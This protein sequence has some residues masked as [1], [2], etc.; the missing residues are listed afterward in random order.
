MRRTGSAVAIR[1]LPYPYRAALTITGDLD[2][3]RTARDFVEVVRFLGGTGETPLGTG[4]GLELS[5][6]FWFY[7]T[8][9]DSEFTVFREGGPE[10]TA[11][12]GLIADLVASGHVDTMHTYGNFSEGGFRR[13]HAERALS[14]LRERR[15]AVPVWVNHGGTKNTQ[16]VG[17]LPEQ[18]GDDPGSVEYHTDLMAECGVRFVETFDVTHTVGQD[19]PAT[20]RDRA[21]QTYEVARYLAS[22]DRGRAERVYRNALVE[23]R[24]LGDGGRFF[25][26]KRFIGRGHGME[27]AGSAELA[28]QLSP[29]VLSELV[30]KRGWMSVYTHPWR[31]PGGAALIAPAAVQALRG[32]AAEAAAGRIYVTTT[33][34]LLTLNLVTRRLVWSSERLD[35][36]RVVRIAHVDD[37]VAGRWAP[38]RSDLSGVTFYVESPHETR[39]FVG[40]DEIDGLVPNPPD[41]TGRP[42]VSVPLKRLPAPDLP[43]F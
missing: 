12:A 1:D 31:N 19:A 5:H 23:P 30:R 10:L 2:D 14:F 28:L 35:G 42:S 43:E 37:E 25:S 8:C 34:R 39:V 26:F 33:S 15:I 4:L 36:K 3:L 17:D 22:G 16:M 24:T 11:H 29:D 9:G 7:D 40:E 32:L 38:S 27:S 21:V 41:E 6:S 18:L 20:L 13:A